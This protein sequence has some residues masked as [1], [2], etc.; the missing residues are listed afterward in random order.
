MSKNV[1]KSTKSSGKSTTSYENELSGLEDSL[2]NLNIKPEKAKTPC[3]LCG[4][5]FVGI[6]IHMVH[7]NRAKKDR[8]DCGNCGYWLRNDHVAKE[9]M[10]KHEKKL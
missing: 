5:E 3:K 10:G 6:A 4:K 1:K 9:L 2:A 8:I 7:C